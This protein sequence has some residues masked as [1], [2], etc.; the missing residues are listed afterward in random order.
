MRRLPGASKSSGICID[1][2]EEKNE[3]DSGRA[4]LHK[5]VKDKVSHKWS[6]LPFSYYMS[7]YDAFGEGV[8]GEDDKI[9]PTN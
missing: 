6:A 5:G 2:K 9:W 3:R 1:G 4:A 8:M 7:H